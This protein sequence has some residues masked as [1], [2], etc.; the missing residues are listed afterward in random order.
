MNVTEILNEAIELGPHG[1]DFYPI[2]ETRLQEFKEK[3]FQPS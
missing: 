2:H 1:G 3:I